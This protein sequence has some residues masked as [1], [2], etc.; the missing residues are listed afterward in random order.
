MSE[1]GEAQVK[2]QPSS[3]APS[4]SSR[5]KHL[6]SFSPSIEVIFKFLTLTWQS[7]RW[8]LWQS[9]SFFSTSHSPSMST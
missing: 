3:K 7:L 9:S 8:S 4:Q 5:Y 1:V 6:P 2:V